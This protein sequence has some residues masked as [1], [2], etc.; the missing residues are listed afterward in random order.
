MGRPTPCPLFRTL[1]AARARGL[2]F[3]AVTDHN[4]ASQNQDLRELAPWFDDL[5]LIPGREISTFRGHANVFGV[6]GP[7]EFQLGGARL[8]DLGRLLD[9]VEA[10]HGLIAVNHPGL[11]SGEACMGCGWTAATDWSRIPA[12]EAVNGGSLE[13]LGAEGPLSGLPTWETQ[14]AAGRRITAIGGSDNHDASAPLERPG[15]VGGPTT[16]VHAPELSQAAILGAI[17][18]GHVFVDVQGSRDR[19]LDVRARSGAATAEM[20]D[21]LP[22]AAG[23]EVALTVT[24]AGV[25]AGSRLSPA[26]DAAALLAPADL[27]LAAG[28]STVALRLGADGRPRW[29]RIDVRGPDGKLLLLGNPVYLRP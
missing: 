22:A 26:G 4:T 13:W 14:L 7:L 6:T 2:D 28:A 21:A 18:A 19:L 27:S 1:E 10:A 17:R 8:P 5:L 29:L 23:A 20:G 15:S 3:V 11:P 16:V 9:A 12:I 25:P 24:V